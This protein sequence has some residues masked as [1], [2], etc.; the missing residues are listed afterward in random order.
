MRKEVTTVT[1]TCDICDK[2]Y[3][4][5]EEIKYL[6]NSGY[7]GNHPTYLYIKPLLMRSGMHNTSDLCRSCVESIILKSIP[8]RV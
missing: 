5:N 6:I 3:D 7:M 1:Y 2:E 4:P 8:K